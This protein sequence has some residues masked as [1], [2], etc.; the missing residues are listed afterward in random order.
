L[1][2]ATLATHTAPGLV[3]RKPLGGGTGMVATS[4]LVWGSMRETV[5][6]LWLSTQTAPDSMA[7]SPG[8]SPTT[9]EATIWLVRR[10]I[11]IADPLASLWTQIAV[12]LAAIQ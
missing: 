9:T 1:S 7:M 4:L 5:L 8:P 6:S 3:V 10:S 2:F 12:S 11:P